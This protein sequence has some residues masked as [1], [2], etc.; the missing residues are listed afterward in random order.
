MKI[1]F[2]LYTYVLVA[3]SRYTKVGF[4]NCRNLNNF[5]QAVE[6]LKFDGLFFKKY[7]PSAKTYTVDLSNIAF[8]YSCV[9]SPNYLC[10]FWN[11]KSFFTTQLLCIFLAQTL[12]TFYKNANFQTFHCSGYSS[13]NSSCHFSNKKSVFL[14]SLDLSWLSWEIILL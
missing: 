1:P 14:E 3:K 5:R 4:K 6:K 9:N 7:I 10:H 12:H 8:N 2:T 13:P 11:H